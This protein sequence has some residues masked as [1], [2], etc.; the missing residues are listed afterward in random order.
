VRVTNKTRIR[1]LK[2]GIYKMTTFGFPAVPRRGANCIVLCDIIQIENVAVPFG[3][4]A[5]I[6]QYSAGL[7]AGRS[8][9]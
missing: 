6:A 9:F 1:K 4:R 3:L 7:R 2:N 8:G 5:V